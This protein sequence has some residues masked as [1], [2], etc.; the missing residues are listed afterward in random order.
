LIA[1]DVLAIIVPWLI[2]V[3]PQC[4]TIGV[5]VVPAVVSWVDG[6]VEVPV[7]GVVAGLPIAL[8]Q[9]FC[10]MAACLWACLVGECV[11]VQSDPGCH[12]LK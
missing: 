7:S 2:C 11:I 6:G 9:N 8:Q 3:N 10:M 1:V 5:W 12:T 4:A